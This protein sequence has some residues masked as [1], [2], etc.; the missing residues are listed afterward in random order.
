LVTRNS[1]K[2]VDVGEALVDEA[3]RRGHERL[4]RFVQG[5]RHVDAERLGLVHHVVNQGRSRRREK[6]GIEDVP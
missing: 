5:Q 3:E 1:R 4:E 2:T 6:R